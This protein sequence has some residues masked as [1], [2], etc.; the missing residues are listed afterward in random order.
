MTEPRH[1][2]RDPLLRRETSADQAAALLRRRITDGLLAPG[3]QLREE[4]LT[5]V[6]GISRNT[7]REAFRMLGHEGLIVRRPYRGV[8][9]RVV[10][11]ADVEDI[12]RTRRLLEPLG[13]DTLVRDPAAAGSLL[14][15]VAAAEEAAAALDWRQVGT[16][17]LDLHRA[18]VQSCRSTR[19]NRLFAQLFAELR[20]AF[21][22]TG[23]A[24][25]MHEP[26]LARNRSVA[27]LI[28]CGKG[29][30]AQR[31]LA[32]YLAQAER[33]VIDAITTA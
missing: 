18:I 9:V 16:A 4:Q 11:V 19:M 22:L 10:T 8:F 12:F 1:H 33:H 21:L 14:D 27:E 13:V 17:N 20:L 3:L 32:D 30:A 2:G 15:I 31:V 24:R 5:A 6:L 28:A 29:Q 26:Y 7:I 23:D 25:A